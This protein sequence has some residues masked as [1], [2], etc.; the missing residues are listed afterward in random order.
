MSVRR[1]L[2]QRLPLV[3]IWPTVARQLSLEPSTIVGV[4]STPLG[5]EA[6]LRIGPPLSAP[7]IG[8][9][10]NQIAVA[11]GMARVR[12]LDDPERADHLR[13]FFD[14]RLSL[15]SLPYPEDKRTV[16][17]PHD[18]ANP[19]PV[20]MDDQGQ[21]VSLRVLG[22]GALLGGNPGSGKSNGLRV[23]LAGLARSRNIEVI[24]ID[25]KRAELVL[26]RDRFSE[27][28]LGHEP[29]PTLDLLERLLAEIHER[30]IFLS[31]TG[32]AT[33]PPSERHPAIVLVVDEWA[34]LGAAGSSKER[35]RIDATLRRV[36]S[37]GRA[38]GCTALLATQ[39]PTG[40][41][42]DVGTRSLLAHRFALRCGDR[43]QADA[44]LGVGSYDPTQ[45]LGAAPGRALW[46]DGGPAR[47]V[48]LFHVPDEMVPDLVH[49]VLRPTAGIWRNSLA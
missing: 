13:L 31:T 44:I 38:V 43:Y 19:I 18:P 29:E 32:G 24:G 3:A 33:L 16:W 11:Y 4:A 9:A 39:R 27:L 17:L 6:R 48:Q 40:D 21:V 34:E 45:L 1:W 37:L 8:L 12:V 14:E 30:A 49:S 22:H 35:Q 47:A 23:L 36:I 15:G 26:W 42:I 20:G 10:A 46:S 28:V 2:Y 5:L 41:T 7:R 25:P